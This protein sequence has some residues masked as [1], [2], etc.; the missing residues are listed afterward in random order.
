M[1]ASNKATYLLTE[2][3]IFKIDLF[4]IISLNISS[5]LLVDCY[6]DKFIADEIKVQ[7]I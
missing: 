4:M 1:N 7:V 5:N 6:Q 2:R 3:R